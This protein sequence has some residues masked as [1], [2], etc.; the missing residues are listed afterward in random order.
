MTKT[1]FKLSEKQLQ[2]LTSGAFT[3]SFKQDL[4][5]P[6]ESF[7]KFYESHKDN[8]KKKDQEMVAICQLFSQFRKQLKWKLSA[9]TITK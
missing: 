9:I 3:T 4:H 5:M 7:K 8:E 1:F 6:S 2:G